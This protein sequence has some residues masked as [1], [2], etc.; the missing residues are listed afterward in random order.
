MQLYD[1][2][3][4]SIN[5]FYKFVIKEMYNNI[6]LIFICFNCNNLIHFE[7]NNENQYL[8]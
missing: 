1:I 6:E 8:W 7:L 2:S 3:Y 4:N 5:M